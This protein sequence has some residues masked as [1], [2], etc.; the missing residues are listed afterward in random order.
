M[1]CPLHT[2]STY[3]V[4]C[5]PMPSYE[6]SVFHQTKPMNLKVDSP[7]LINELM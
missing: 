5:Q 2:P 3:R 6:T 4:K 7:K 1:E